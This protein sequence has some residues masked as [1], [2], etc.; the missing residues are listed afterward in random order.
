[1]LA[2]QLHAAC[3]TAAKHI[4]DKRARQIQGAPSGR[5]VTA[6]VHA[7]RDRHAQA[8]GCARERERVRAREGRSRIWESAAGF[9]VPNFVLAAV[10]E[11]SV[12]RWR[13]GRPNSS[14][15]TTRLGTCE[16]QGGKDAR[17]KWQPPRKMLDKAKI[18]TV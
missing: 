10:T 11:K 4:L 12:R 2:Q 6:G 17:A 18:G 3:V 8:G 15:F 7:P 1:M 13:S 14:F 5:L 16:A 9:S